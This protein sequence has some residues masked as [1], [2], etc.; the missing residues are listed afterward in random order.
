MGLQRA[1]RGFL[2][3]AVAP[4]RPMME[5]LANL[6]VTRSTKV[7][8]RVTV[9]FGK[10]PQGGSVIAMVNVGNSKSLMHQGNNVFVS[11]EFHVE[12]LESFRYWYEIWNQFNRQE[13]EPFKRAV[14]LAGQH[15]RY[16]DVT[17]A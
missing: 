2:G 4:A 1:E 11:V 3:I 16:A 13:S 9:P 8:L 7:Q 17:D 12:S 10:V 14:P 5:P 15:D 6:H